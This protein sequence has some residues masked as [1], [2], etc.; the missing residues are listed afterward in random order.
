M[1][2]EVLVADSLWVDLIL[3]HHNMNT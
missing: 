2:Y 3:F 1:D